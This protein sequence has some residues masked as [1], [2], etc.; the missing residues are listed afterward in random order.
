M[1]IAPTGGV[2]ASAAG[3]NLAQ[4]AGADVQRTQESISNHQRQAASDDA[5]DS[6]AGIA[7]S[8]GQSHEPHE[9]DADGRRSWEIGPPSHP[10]AAGDE[11]T[12]EPTRSQD[13]GEQCGN[14]VDL[15]A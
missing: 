12:R 11:S 8:D 9:R 3:S 13:A 4:S 1:S 2:F 14:S 6:A 7:E 5:A 10:V 15:T